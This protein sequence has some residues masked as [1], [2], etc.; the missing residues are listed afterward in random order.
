MDDSAENDFDLTGAFLGFQHL[1]CGA[2]SELAQRLCE[3]SSRLR[4]VAKRLH[5]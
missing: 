4:F 5:R 3:L 2:P 1:D